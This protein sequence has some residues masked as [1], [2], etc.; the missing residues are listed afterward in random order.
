MSLSSA[1][2]GGNATINQSGGTTQWASPMSLAAGAEYNLSGGTLQVDTIS[3]AGDWTLAMTGGTLKVATYTGDLALTGGTLA[4]GNSPGTT[5]VSG[6]YSQD[7]S[8]TLEI[9]LGGTAQGTTY[10]YVDVT[11][12]ASL[13]GFLEVILW[14]GFTPS[15]NATFDVLTASSITDNGLTLTGASGFTYS[16]E[17]GDTLR[18]TYVPEPTTLGLLVI[19]GLVCLHRRKR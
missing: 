2:I 15:E 11:G 13:D 8:S 5:T 4:P 6:A 9:E 18:L 19:G 10:D 3:N 17:G 1:T 7:D 14:D 12:S 16:I